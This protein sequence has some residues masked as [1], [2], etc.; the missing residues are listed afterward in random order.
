M[1]VRNSQQ[2]A[3]RVLTP[4]HELGM[5]PLSPVRKDFKA[6]SGSLGKNTIIHTT[7]LPWAQN[8]RAYFLWIC[9]LAP[10]LQTEKLSPREGRWLV[11]GILTL[12]QDLPLNKVSWQNQDL[13]LLH[14][15]VRFGFVFV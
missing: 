9:Y 15:L 4:S 10:V 3:S 13:W 6:Q 11:Q 14:Y 5:A 12:N 2:V 7:R 8:G 1:R